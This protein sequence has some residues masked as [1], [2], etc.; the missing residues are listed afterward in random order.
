MKNSSLPCFVAVLVWMGA[1]CMGSVSENGGGSGGGTGAGSGGAG[2]PACAGG[3]IMCAGGS[4][5]INTTSDAAHCGGCGKACSGGQVCDL[6]TCATTC[7]AG[8]M[9]C[10][11]SCANIS[12]D[13]AH[14]GDCTTRCRTDQI[15]SGGG[16]ACPTGQT[17]CNGVCA[18]SCGGG[19]TGGGTG[20]GGAAGGSGGTTST[21][22][23]GGTATL[24]C[25][26]PMPGR[27]PLHRLTA[28]SYNNTV[29]D[30]LKDTTNPG[31]AFPPEALGNG[32]GNDADEQSVGPELAIGYGKVAEGI[33]ARATADATALGNL[34]PCAATATTANEE[35]CARTV[36]TNLL[37]RAYRR[38]VTTAELDELVSVYRNVRAIS[39]TVTFRSGVAAMIEVVLQ[40]PEFLYLVEVGTAD[41]ASPSVKKL[42]G[43]ELATR[44]SYYLW[45]TMPDTTLTTAADAGALGTP[46]GIMAEA[47]RLLGDEKAR[48]VV[49][50]FFDNVLP[51]SNLTDLTRD[52]GQ[53]PTFS[54]AIGQAM[55]QE[56]QATLQYEIFENTTQAPG[57]PYAAGSWPALLTAPYTFVNQALFNFYGPT[58]FSGTT[59]VTGTALQKVNLNTSQRLGLLTQ[60]GIMTGT[61]TTNLTNPVRRG[62]FI[63]NELMCRNISFPTDPEL[64]ALAMQ[65]VPYTGWTSR[66]RYD[67]HR[68]MAVCA[69]CHQ[70][71]D[72][73]GFALENYDAVGLYRTSE[74]ATINGETRTTGIDTTGM[75][76]GVGSWA[77]P[78]E[79]VQKLAASDEIQACFATRW[80]EYG[81]GR[82]LDDKDACN[83]QSLQTAFKSS[84]YNIKKMLLALTQ[85]DA[86]RY[87]SAQ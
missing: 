71:M 21:G 50:H 20:A 25:S 14:C 57:S 44:L 11:T 7:S 6:G 13:P 30:L 79:L 43:R 34:A 40:S 51:L 5:C 52:P 69:G 10:G 61:A 83:R 72:P 58:A 47:T 12:N 1:A 2:P 49:G 87:R 37:P 27:S 86:F 46:A 48:P 42:T 75:V 66:E 82:H 17:L 60:G 81:Y 74:R 28:F 32:F 53:F 73:V 62:A 39:T 29:R 38:T 18:V 26:S 67:K 45:Q 80:M 31:N 85:T 4:T 77:T 56:T 54:A 68:S 15:C 9:L 22:G 19:G 35:S 23:S 78:I 84:G 24:A 41:P 76:P 36:A 16:C 70:F 63:I 64:A 3:L 59:S 33:A 55:R 65:P 8:A